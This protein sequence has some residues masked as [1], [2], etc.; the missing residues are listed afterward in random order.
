MLEQ[1]VQVSVRSLGADHSTTISAQL[2]LGEAYIATGNAEE[3]GAR[4]QRGIGERPSHRRCEAARRRAALDGRCACGR[5]RLRRC[6][7]VCKRV[8]ATRRHEARQRQTY[9][10]ARAV[11]GRGH[12]VANALERA[13]SGLRGA[14][15]T[16]RM[17][18][19]VAGQR[20]TCS[21]LARSMRTFSG[22]R[23]TRRLQSPSFGRCARSSCASS[24]AVPMPMSCART[25]A[26]VPLLSRLGDPVSAIASYREAIQGLAAQTGGGRC[27]CHS[28]EP[29]EARRSA[30]RCPTLR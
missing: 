24:E 22:R 4:Y 28:Q 9:G 20:R 5:R 13:P 26:S 3:R 23:E 27:R 10:D 6:N 11:A 29:H 16:S 8:R 18:T 19:G 30:A 12:P 21:P 14:P 7:Q 17:N 2:N 25:S 1:A 15:M